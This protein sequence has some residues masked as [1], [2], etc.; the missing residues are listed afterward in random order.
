MPKPDDIADAEFLEVCARQAA[1]VKQNFIPNLRGGLVLLGLGDSLVAQHEEKIH[2]RVS[3]MLGRVRASGVESEDYGRLEENGEA[4]ALDRKRLFEAAG[5][6]KIDLGMGIRDELAHQAI[7]ALQPPWAADEYKLPLS[8]HEGGAEALSNL[9][10]RSTC[11]KI[12]HAEHLVFLALVFS[13]PASLGSVLKKDLMAYNLTGFMHSAEK[14]GE[15]KEIDDIV[16]RY[17]S[18]ES[19]LGAAGAMAAKKMLASNYIGPE[20]LQFLAEVTYA[21]GI[22]DIT[23]RE[24]A[25]ANVLAMLDAKLAKP[26]MIAGR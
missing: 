2:A 14:P 9:V 6:N 22:D 5:R 23:K 10:L 15:K 25:R 8:L 19:R 13:A 7:H 20:G 12:T 11:G 26:G 16:L 24:N 18:V 1:W 3:R 17:S 4:V 21:K